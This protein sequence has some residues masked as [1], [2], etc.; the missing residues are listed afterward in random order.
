M[1]HVRTNLML[2]DVFTKIVSNNALGG[3]VG[4]LIGTGK[5]PHTFEVPKAFK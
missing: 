3:L 2:S 5:Q 1:F 4:W